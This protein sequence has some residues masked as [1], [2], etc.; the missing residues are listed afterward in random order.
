MDIDKYRINADE[1]VIKETAKHLTR[2]QFI[3]NPVILRMCPPNDRCECE[4]EKFFI[5]KIVSQ[6]PGSS[7][8]CRICWEKYME[9]LYFKE[10]YYNLIDAIIKAHATSRRIK[11]KNW[12]TFE[13][14]DELSC[15]VVFSIRLHSIDIKDINKKVWEVY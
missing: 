15:L 3:N 1:Q 5:A 10:K 6:L 7:R 12:A 8:A 4:D 13:T 9:N 11:H 14:L 2:Y